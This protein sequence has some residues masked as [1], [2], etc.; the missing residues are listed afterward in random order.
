[1]AGTGASGPSILI[2]RG[3]GGRTLLLRATEH[4]FSTARS[5][6]E[7]SDGNGN[8]ASN[9]DEEDGVG[10]EV[11]AMDGSVQDSDKSK[12]EF[13]ITARPVCVKFFRDRGP[14]ER[15]IEAR[16]KL[17]PKELKDSPLPPIVP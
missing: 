10:V 13:R 14:Y 16:S 3:V 2:H 9:D 11:S 8:A 6:G 7:K 17:F 15:E 12:T 1:M 5:A 4:T